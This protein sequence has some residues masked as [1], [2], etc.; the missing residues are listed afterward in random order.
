VL[1]LCNN[2]TARIRLQRDDKPEDWVAA[3]YK[4]G[5]FDKTAAMRV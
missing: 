3:F 1:Q 4:Q 2:Y 5:K